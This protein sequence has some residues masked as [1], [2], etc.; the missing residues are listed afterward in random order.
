MEWTKHTDKHTPSTVASA[1]HTH[2]IARILL[3]VVSPCLSQQLAHAV[4]GTRVG[5]QVQRSAVDLS[6]GTK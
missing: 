4:D 3:V 1:E 5:G 2:H 6:N